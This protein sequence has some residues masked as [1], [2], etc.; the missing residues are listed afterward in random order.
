MVGHV[1]EVA[2][3]KPAVKLDRCAASHHAEPPYPLELQQ[4]H[5]HLEE[6]VEA[7]KVSPISKPFLPGSSHPDHP[8]RDAV[9]AT[10]LGPSKGG[11]DRTRVQGPRS[12]L[13]LNQCIKSS[14]CFSHLQGPCRTPRLRLRLAPSPR[15][16]RVRSHGSQQPFL[17]VV[18]TRS[19]AH[20]L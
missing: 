9:A 5:L 6:E 18:L 13:F 11:V 7:P 10:P 17:R 14:I 2:R 15:Q 19:W 4:H 16:R 12:L 20:N 8:P 3:S 1:L